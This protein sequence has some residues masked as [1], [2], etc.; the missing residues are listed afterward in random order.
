MFW[1]LWASLIKVQCLISSIEADCLPKWKRVWWPRAVNAVICR[2][3]RDC[4]F[5]LLVLH[6]KC[7]Q[8]DWLRA[9]VFQ[10][11]VKYLQPRTKP[12]ETHY[13]NTYFFHSPWQKCS[14]SQIKRPFP[15]S[16]FAMLIAI[17]KEMHTWA[18]R[19][20]QHCNRGGEG[21]EFVPFETKIAWREIENCIEMSQQFC[22]GLS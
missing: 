2:D 20:K 12:V 10:L 1:L 15:P 8:F 22:P 17:T 19:P 5:E 3:F 9:V 16:P 18:V 11:N 7:L 21:G 14:P 6:E 13:K 4:R